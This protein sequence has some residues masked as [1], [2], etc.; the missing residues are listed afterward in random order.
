MHANRYMSIARWLG[1]NDLVVSQAEAVKEKIARTIEPSGNMPHETGRFMS[2]C[3]L[4]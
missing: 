1:K 4:L 2:V 3:V